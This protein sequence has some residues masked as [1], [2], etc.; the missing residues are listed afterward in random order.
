MGVIELLDVS[1]SSV[2]KLSLQW[3]VKACVMNHKDGSTALV[4]EYWFKCRVYYVQ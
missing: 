3:A 4:E 1:P 2:N